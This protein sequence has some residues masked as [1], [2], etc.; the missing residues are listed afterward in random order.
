[1]KQSFLCAACFACIIIVL[2]CNNPTNNPGGPTATGNPPTIPYDPSP[3]DSVI[4]VGRNVFLLW[5]T[6]DPDTGDSTLCDIYMSKTY[7]PD[8]Q[9]ASNIR[10]LGFNAGRLDSLSTYYW[11]VFVRDLHGHSV[12]GPV[13]RFTTG[14]F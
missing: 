13:W 9:I 7:P 8:I 5:H 3:N 2:S 4:G 12:A 11:A 14:Q 1:M 10:I 6:E